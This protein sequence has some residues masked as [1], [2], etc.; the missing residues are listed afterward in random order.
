MR[1]FLGI[2]FW[3]CKQDSHIYN[4]KSGQIIPLQNRGFLRR[5]QPFS[6]ETILLSP[7]NFCR[8]LKQK[9]PTFIPTKRSA[10]LLGVN[11]KGEK[12]NENG[13]KFFHLTL[14]WHPIIGLKLKTWLFN[15]DFQW[16]FRNAQKLEHF[17]CELKQCCLLWLPLVSILDYLLCEFV[18]R[19]VWNKLQWRKLNFRTW[20][21]FW[22]RIK[23]QT[24]PTKKRTKKTCD[25]AT[26]TWQNIAGRLF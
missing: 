23:K 6:R 20:I 5:D 12:L 9:N 1:P 25:E 2:R 13:S 7:T 15:M 18:G 21:C 3:A 17:I 14:K 22:G 4:G 24:G 26:K 19:H 10:L 11:C 16:I 8:F